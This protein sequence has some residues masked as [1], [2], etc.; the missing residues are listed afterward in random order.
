MTSRIPTHVVMDTSDGFIWWR[1]SLAQG[2][3]LAS[4][5]AWA[6]DSNAVMKPEHRTYRVYALAQ[7][8]A[9]QDPANADCTHDHET[10]NALTE[11]TP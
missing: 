10:C 4:A 8:I 3:T 9:C 11:V 2:F 7:V 6:H 5:T 1:D